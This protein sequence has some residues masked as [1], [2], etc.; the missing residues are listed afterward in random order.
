MTPKQNQ[1]TA[2]NLRGQ[3]GNWRYYVDREYVGNAEM[4][5]IHRN[6]R[7]TATARVDVIGKIDAQFGEVNAETIAAF[8]ETADADDAAVCASFLA[9]LEAGK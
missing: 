8:M 1:P 7:N 9:K 5:Q 4:K 2:A 6:N 3:G